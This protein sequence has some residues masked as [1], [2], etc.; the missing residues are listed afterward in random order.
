LGSKST[1][2]HIFCSK[3]YA[4]QSPHQ[5]RNLV[6]LNFKVSVIGN[7]DGSAG[8]VNWLKARRY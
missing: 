4:T 7:L 5:F 3:L 2:F 6:S 8:I 1:D